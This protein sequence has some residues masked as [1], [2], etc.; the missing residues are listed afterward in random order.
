M[1]FLHPVSGMAAAQILDRRHQVLDMVAAVHGHGHHRY[2]ALALL[3]HIALEKRAQRGIALEQPIVE[4]G[5]RLFGNL[6]DL[7]KFRLHELN[8]VRRHVGLP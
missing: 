2:Q 5:G 1:L 4:H 7:G 3:R 8:F 6:C